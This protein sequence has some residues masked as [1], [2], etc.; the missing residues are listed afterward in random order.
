M[1]GLAERDR[2]VFADCRG[3]KIPVA[4]AMAGGYARH[5]DDT[6]AIHRATILLARQMWG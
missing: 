1:S 6:V 3:R 5:I 4:I 2:R